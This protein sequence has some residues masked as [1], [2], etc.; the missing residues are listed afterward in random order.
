MP[1]PV[2]S[3]KEEMITPM[4]FITLYLSRIVFFLLLF[5]G[6]WWMLDGHFGLARFMVGGMVLGAIVATLELTREY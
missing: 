5:L 4:D 3:E 2:Q 1:E 6:A